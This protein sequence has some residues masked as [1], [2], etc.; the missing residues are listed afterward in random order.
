MSL[1][2]FA[3]ILAFF[4]FLDSTLSRTMPSQAWVVQDSAESKLS[5]FQDSAESKLSIFQDS[6]ESK[7]STVY[8]RVLS[9]M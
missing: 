3:G 6:A 9:Q 8:C 4:S 2:G 5:T 7:L 1:L